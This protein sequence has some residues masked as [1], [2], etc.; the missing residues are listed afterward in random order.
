IASAE[1]AALRD[2]EPP[3]IDGP[4]EIG[5]L[6]H[7]IEDMAQRIAERAELQA[8]LA[9]GDRLA[10]VGVMSASVAHEINNPLT[11]I[12]GYAKLLQEDKGEDHLDRA[13]LELIES[14]AA[15]M[16]AIVS[17][18]LDYARV[19]KGTRGPTDVAAVVRHVAALMQPQLRRARVALELTVDDGLPEVAADAHAL[20]QV[21]VNLVQNAAQAM[22]GA[23]GAVRARASIEPGGH[24]V[25]IEVSDEGPGVS[26]EERARIFDPFYTTKEAGIGTGLGLAVCKHLVATFGGTIDAGDGPGGRGAAFRV[27]IPRAES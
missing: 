9:R 19:E 24:A 12:L 13:G 27:V 4:G 8:A 6:A 15:R 18:L 16:K 25:R 1:P 10:T 23:A 21:L 20:Q 2:G 7:R 17:G 22:Q 11:T 26:P 14:E 3:R 5:V